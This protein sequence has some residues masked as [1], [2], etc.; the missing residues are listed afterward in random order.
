MAID[1]GGRGGTL[2]EMGGRTGGVIVT[3][4]G[5]IGTLGTIPEVDVGGGSTAAIVELP[6]GPATLPPL[7]APGPS[8]RGK[9]GGIER[10]RL[11]T[12]ARRRNS[13]AVDTPLGTR[14]V[15]A[16]WP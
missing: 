14:L 6:G 16:A 10:A 7:P 15:A 8:A 11:R 5:G 13:S 12:Q 9:R 2:T 1:T 4:P 3:A